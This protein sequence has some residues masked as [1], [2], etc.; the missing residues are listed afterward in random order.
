MAESAHTQPQ[1][2]YAGPIHDATRSGD[3]S[4]MREMEQ[5]AQQHLDEVRGALD[6]LRAALGRHNG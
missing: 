4:R 3:E 6:E 2:L 1:P 5:R